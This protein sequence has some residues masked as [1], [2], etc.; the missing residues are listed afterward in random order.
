MGL[1]M[2]V[3][4]LLV[5]RVPEI[6]KK[7]HSVRDSQT[8]VLQRLY[9]W[10]FLIMLNVA[11]IF[12]RPIQERVTGQ[13]ARTAVQLP[14]QESESILS[15][16]EA[17]EKLAEKLC[18]YDVVSFDVFDTLLFRP[19]S[20]PAD[21][22][23]IVGQKL[24]YLDF[25][26]IRMEAEVRARQEHLKKFGNSEVTLQEIYELL[27][28]DAGIPCEEGM[29]AEVETEKEM[30]F[31]NPYMLQVF[32][33]LREAGKRIIVL[34]DMYLSGLCIR[35]IL[36]KCG[37]TG[38]SQCLVSS[39]CGQ[40]KAEGSL[41]QRAAE[42]L[43]PGETCIHVGDNRKSDADNAL[44]AGWKAVYYRNVNHIGK[45]YRAREM[46]AVSGSIYRGL[47]NAHIHNGLR[48]YSREYEYGFIY[49]GIFVLGYCQFIHEYVSS[50]QVDKIL[51]LARDGDILKQVYDQMYPEEA[52]SGRTCYAL[53]SR[54]AAA[55]LSARYYKHDYYRR[56]LFHK[57]NQGFSLKQIFETMEIVDMLDDMEARTG[58][59]L[60]R[61]QELTDRNVRDVKEYL[62]SRWIRVL[63]HYDGQLEAGKAYYA[64]ILKSCRNAAAVDIGWAGSGAMA[65]DVVVNRMWKL[66]CH[67]VGLVAG[68]NSAN[69]AEPD[70]SEAQLAQ[71]KLVSYLFSQA[72][73]RDLWSRHN[74][75]KGDNVMMEKLLASP[76]P[77]F[78]GF[79]SENSGELNRGVSA[80]GHGISEEERR[81]AE[82]IQRGIRDFCQIYLNHPISGYV[83]N[84][85]GRDA[86][87]PAYLWMAGNRKQMENEDCQCVLA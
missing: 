49:G 39:D 28:D 20:S 65:L 14:K 62:N 24:N 45:K 8:T 67:I 52:E 19:F 79:D 42:L 15:H 32:Q 35:M 12:H 82:E 25:R 75:A 86:A 51:F 61:D 70:M 78:R 21:L 53:W 72:H 83:G 54:L 27:E 69:S 36:E 64:N 18:A 59:K 44:R 3:Y 76:F 10:M 4:G 17:P 77:S 38:I 11:W 68:T 63:S 80:G 73:N 46:S 2:K 1:R 37:F 40:S 43:K 47:V 48:I 29:Q 85:S 5:N 16:L 26:R 41:Y 60:D 6:Q 55:K 7:Y 50:H 56:F 74:A 57:V 71:G 9:A 87:A 30:C 31:A 84:I 13:D 34:S 33:R 22:F 66:D 23:Y 58:G 81:Q